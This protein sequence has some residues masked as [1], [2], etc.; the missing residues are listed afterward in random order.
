MRVSPSFGAFLSAI[1][2]GTAALAATVTPEQGE[3]LVNTGAGYKPVW[4]SMQVSPGDQVMAKPKASGRVVYSDDC[5]VRVSPG[6]VLTIAPK[7]PCE[8]TA[9]HIETAAGSPPP[10]QTSQ[11][12]GGGNDV[13]PFL[14]VV[15]VPVG[16]ALL[17][18][19][20]KAA[21]P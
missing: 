6:M 19:R 3:L 16:M 9:R 7:S 18:T 10:A 21:S 13:V 14:A 5:I 15:G 8:R 4:Q 20:D 12:P 11:G 1:F 17:P 2:F